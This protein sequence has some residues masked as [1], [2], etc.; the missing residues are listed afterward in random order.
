[1]NM[2]IYIMRRTVEM[3]EHQDR[4]PLDVAVSIAHYLLEE[5]VNVIVI[6]PFQT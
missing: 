6:S 2:N 4:M 5:E 1:M 3:V